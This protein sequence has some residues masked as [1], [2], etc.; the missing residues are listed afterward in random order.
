MWME[1]KIGTRINLNRVDEAISTGAEEVAVAE[2]VAEEVVDA[3]AP[4]EEV[5]E[6]EVAEA[7]AEAPEADEAK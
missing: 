1:E 2:V 3:P 4:V 7:A 6:A 5:A